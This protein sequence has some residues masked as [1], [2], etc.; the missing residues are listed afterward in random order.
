MEQRSP[1]WMALHT[2]HITSSSFDTVMNG[3]EKAWLSLI[4]NI[5]NHREFYSDATEWGKQYEDEALT[6]FEIVTGIDTY[7]IG[8]ATHDGIKF[9]GCSPDFLVNP[10]VGGEIKCP[11]N[12]ANHFAVMMSKAVPK[13]YVAQV[14]G[15]MWCT[16]RKQW[17]FLSYDPRQRPEHRLVKILVNRD[18]DYIAKLERKVLNFLRVWKDGEPASKYFVNV[19]GALP[20]LF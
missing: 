20:K 4:K 19:D 6:L 14:Q 8:F 9:V 17:W 3:G 13:Q 2:D 11:K 18:D 10:L 5:T 15:G 1:E 7:K 16:G 12:S